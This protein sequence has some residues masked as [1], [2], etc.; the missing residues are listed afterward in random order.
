MKTTLNYFLIITFAFLTLHCGGA[1]QNSVPTPNSGGLRAL[2]SCDELV[3]YYANLKDSSSY[4]SENPTSSPDETDFTESSSDGDFSSDTSSDSDIS[5][6]TTNH[7]VEEADLAK[8]YADKLLTSHGSKLYLYQVA[9][10]DEANLLATLDLSGT[11]QELFL[12]DDWAAVFTTHSFSSDSSL[13][14]GKIARENRLWLIDLTDPENPRIARK[15][16]IEENYVTSRYDSTDEVLYWVSK[17]YRSSGKKELDEIIPKAALTT[18][19]DSASIATELNESDCSN[20]LVPKEDSDYNH[21]Y[22]VSVV[23]LPISANFDSPIFTAGIVMGVPMNTILRATSENMLL[24]I[25]GTVD[26]TQIFA[27]DYFDGKKFQLTAAGSVPGYLNDQFSLD[28][29]SGYVRVAYTQIEGAEDE[30][31]WGVSYNYLEVLKNK[32][33]T[34]SSIAKV[35]P[36]GEGEEVFASHFTNNW[37]Y[38]VT[39]FRFTDPLF[40]IDLTDPENPILTGELDIP[41]FS[42][43]MESVDENNLLTIGLSGEADVQLSLFDV[44]DRTNPSLKFSHPFED[45]PN[46]SE[47]LGDYRAFSYFADDEIV[48]LPI[49]GYVWEES[50]D[51]YYMPEGYSYLVIASVDVNTGFN[52]KSTLSASDVFEIPEDETECDWDFKRTLMVKDTLIAVTSGGIALFDSSNVE[53]PMTTFAFERFI[54]EDNYCAGSMWGGMAM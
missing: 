33:E 7:E 42:T 19:D 20:V 21:N 17:G 43:Y 31:G 32:G 46:G 40:T 52:I 8:S 12:G 50:D 15:I 47:A 5:S 36:F 53:S 34:L 16:A 29:R 51:Y 38:V 35:G 1:G 14:I 28:S 10:V 54:G 41:G 23:A 6:D 9:P 26:G 11:I 22:W 24:A 4:G 25:Q 2:Q 27:F 48:A 45:L 37:G 49:S 39:S 13:M 30:W 18:G 44:K 3:T